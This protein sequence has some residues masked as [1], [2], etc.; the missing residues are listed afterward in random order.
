MYA[1]TV[2]CDHTVILAYHTWRLIQKMA[3]LSQHYLKLNRFCHPIIY[4][5]VT[6]LCGIHLPCELMVVVGSKASIGMGIGYCGGTSFPSQHQRTPEMEGEEVCNV[7]FK[8]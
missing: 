5:L 2:V 6:I 4:K 7:A 8:I 1:C 3:A